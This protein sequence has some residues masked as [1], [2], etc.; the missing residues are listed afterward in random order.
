[1]RCSPNL[2]SEGPGLRSGQSGKEL[3]LAK[4]FLHRETE[5]QAVGVPWK[6]EE[7]STRRAS[8]RNIVLESNVELNVDVG[9]VLRFGFAAPKV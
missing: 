9:L 4:V 3:V 6:Q 5:R 2:T 7:T 8:L 1:I